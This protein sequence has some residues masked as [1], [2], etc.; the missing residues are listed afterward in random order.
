[1]RATPPAN[2]LPVR[3][4]AHHRQ[5]L[6]NLGWNSAGSGFESLAA[7][8]GPGHSSGLG[9]FMSAGHLLFD[10]FSRTSLSPTGCADFIWP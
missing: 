1:M 8:K 10:A 2:P 9:F 5:T 3:A 4:F 7:H 6:I